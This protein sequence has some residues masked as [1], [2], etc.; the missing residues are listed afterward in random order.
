MRTRDGCLKNQTTSEVMLLFVLGF[1]ASAHILCAQTTSP[2]DLSQQIEKLTESM[3]RTQAQV[4]QSQRQLDEMRKELTAL[5][6]QLAQSASTAAAPISPGPPLASPRAQG[7]ASS[8]ASS[9][10]IKQVGERQVLQESQIAIHEQTKVE[11]ES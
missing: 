3:A 8:A 11:S 9:A 6:G 4:E 10:A 5:R 7:Q 2:D 1:G